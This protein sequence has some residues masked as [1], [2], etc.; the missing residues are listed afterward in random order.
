LY[1]QQEHEEGNLMAHVHVTDPAKDT[2]L[3]QVNTTAGPVK[4]SVGTNGRIDAY[5]EPD[6]LIVYLMAHQGY[7]RQAAASLVAR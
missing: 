1:Q 4:V 3:G 2:R 6:A 5:G 7:T